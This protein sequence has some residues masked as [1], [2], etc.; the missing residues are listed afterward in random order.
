MSQ[1]KYVVHA[2]MTYSGDVTVYDIG[3]EDFLYN[4]F[5]PY[6]D[7]KYLVLQEVPAE[8][9]TITQPYLWKFDDLT[10]EQMFSM[11]PITTFLDS[12]GVHVVQLEADC[13]SFGTREQA[14]T[15]LDLCTRQEDNM[16]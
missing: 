2:S 14:I 12:I 1:S 8:T 10:I 6:G 15:Y 7:Y 4:L 9:Y 13:P 3:C 5:V 16:Q 11:Y